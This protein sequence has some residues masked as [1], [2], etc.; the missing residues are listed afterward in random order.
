M[1]SSLGK[2]L[3]CLHR[4]EQGADMIE[5]VLV[6]AAIALPILAVAIIFRNEIWEKVQ[7]FWSEITGGI[8]VE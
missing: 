4:D 1:I 7:D 3:K 6:I 8:R 5:Y 2:Q